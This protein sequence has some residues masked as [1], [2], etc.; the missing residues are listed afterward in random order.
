M[1][2]K[3]FYIAC[4]FILI[5]N[6][7]LGQIAQATISATITTPVGAEISGDIS[8]EELQVKIRSTKTN[9]RITEQANNE[10]LSPIKVIGES[11]AYNVSIEN[12]TVLIKSRTDINESYQSAKKSVEYLSVMVNFD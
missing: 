11:F 10:K 6:N 3:L 7:V 9:E 8:L 5:Q 4:F 1:M 2:V 12:E